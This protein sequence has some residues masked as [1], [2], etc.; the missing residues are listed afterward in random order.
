MEKKKNGFKIWKVILILFIIAFVFA[1]QEIVRNPEKYGGTT[2]QILDVNSF[3]KNA[4][5]T[6]SEEGLVNMIG[7][8]ERKEEWTYP[9][10]DNT[11][12]DLVTYSYQNNEF[13][14][15]FNNNQLV[16]ISINKKIKYSSEKTI[17]KLFNLTNHDITTIDNKK[18]YIKIYN[19]SVPEVWCGISNGNIEW[20]RITFVNNIFD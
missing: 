17:F 14:Y 13:D 5:D 11:T 19:S 10:L 15:I 18:T 6:I 12:L 2:Q 16:R 4:V 1:F 7:E 3:Y 20:T 8:P 9:K